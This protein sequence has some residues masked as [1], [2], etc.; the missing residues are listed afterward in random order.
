MM[1]LPPDINR[2]VPLSDAEFRAL[3]DDIL[4]DRLETNDKPAP[5]PT[6]GEKRRQRLI[7]D[8]GFSGINLPSAEEFDRRFKE[9]RYES[10]R[11]D[12]VLNKERVLNGLPKVYYPNL[13]EYV[14]INFNIPREIQMS[15]DYNY[16]RKTIR[17]ECKRLKKLK[18]EGKEA[19]PWSEW[20]VTS[21]K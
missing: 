13:D 5:E 14:L 4:A 10:Y 19:I 7:N 9:Q 6:L 18:A 21:K 12:A 2:P 3:M 16:M 8:D 20:K 15:R 17:D 1:G 11:A